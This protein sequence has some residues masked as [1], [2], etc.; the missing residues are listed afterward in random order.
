MKKLRK[1]V[2]ALKVRLYVQ[3][4]DKICLQQDRSVPGV[5]QSC[6][7]TPDRSRCIFALLHAT[8][9]DGMHRSVRYD[10]AC[11]FSPRFFFSPAT[12]PPCSKPTFILD[13]FGRL[14]LTF[15][16]RDRRTFYFVCARALSSPSVMQYIFYFIRVFSTSHTH[17]HTPHI[18]H[19][20]IPYIYNIYICV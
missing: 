3:T 5:V 12:P 6:V 9:A 8:N 10:S 2:S 1:L 16:S 7:S 15:L 14:L 11:Q 19:R 20:Y 17:T 4:N 18:M 13:N